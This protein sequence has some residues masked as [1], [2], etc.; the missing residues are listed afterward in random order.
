MSA[1]AGAGQG[2]AGA[3][4]GAGQGRAGA[5]PN[6]SMVVRC[7]QA[8]KAGVVSFATCL[9]EGVR[10]TVDR[11]LVLFGG[12]IVGGVGLVGYLMTVSK[13][14]D[15][16]CPLEC[17]EACVQIVSDHAS[18]RALREDDVAIIGPSVVTSPTSDDPRDDILVDIFVKMLGTV[19]GGFL[20]LLICASYER[21]SSIRKWML[22]WTS[23][24]RRE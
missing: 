1:G 16:A 10:A 6:E 5:N 3:N 8:C 22:S 21:R 9:D 15:V 2:G 12:A 14:D 19:V 20:T 24:E 11:A 4:P 7:F 18:G 17:V 13:D 23:R